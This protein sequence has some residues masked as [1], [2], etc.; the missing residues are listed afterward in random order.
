MAIVNRYRDDAR[1]EA[2]AHADQR[3]GSQPQAWR[4]R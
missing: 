4:R 1:L 2:A 3:R